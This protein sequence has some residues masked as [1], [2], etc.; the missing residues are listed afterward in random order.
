MHGTLYGA[1]LGIGATQGT[2]K[3]TDEAIR[4]LSLM[5]FTAQASV[6]HAMCALAETFALRYGVSEPSEQLRRL[7]ELVPKLPGMSSK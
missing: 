7:F 2:P 6:L 4:N 5:H 1:H 3:D